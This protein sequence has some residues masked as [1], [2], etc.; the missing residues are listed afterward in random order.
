MYQLELFFL[1]CEVKNSLGLRSA[2]EAPGFLHESFASKW[3]YT[4]NASSI[5]R[6]T[7]GR[8]YGFERE[9]AGF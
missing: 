4:N 3:Y 7:D 5:S 6:C 8:A 9:C 2:D 1:E